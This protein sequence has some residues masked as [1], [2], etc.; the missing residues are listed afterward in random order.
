[1]S[2]PRGADTASV[3]AGPRHLRATEQV[4]R[5]DLLP[6]GK[7]QDRPPKMLYEDGTGIRSGALDDL[8][9]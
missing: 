1:V 5:Y 4:I 3:P 7:V 2:G 9:N 6:G 8:F